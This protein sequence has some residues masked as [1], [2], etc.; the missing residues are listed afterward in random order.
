[1][2]MNIESAFQKS[3]VQGLSRLTLLYSACEVALAI[4][5]T[6]IRSPLIV[7]NLF[8]LYFVMLC[9]VQW[10]W[11]RLTRVAATLS[12]MGRCGGVGKVLGCQSLVLSNYLWLYWYTQRRIQKLISCVVIFICATALHWVPERPH[13]C[14]YTGL[15]EISLQLKG[16]IITIMVHQIYCQLFNVDR[17]LRWH[18]MQFSF[19]SS[20]LMEYACVL[21]QSCLWV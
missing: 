5:D 20:L 6:F 4:I 15:P 12:G 19:F 8:L 2:I 13:A 11:W 1:M 14:S 10:Q 9:H 18:D 7:C 16:F 3:L 21:V 17:L